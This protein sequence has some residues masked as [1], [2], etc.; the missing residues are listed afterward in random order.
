MEKKSITIQEIAD[1]LDH[2]LLRPDI[3]VQELKEGCALAK[4]YKCISVCVRPSD[5]PIVCEE[6]KGS[7]VLATTVIG[8]PHG[9][10]TTETKVFETQDAV[11]KG[12]VEVDMV[13]NIGRMK[14][15]EYD[16]VQDEIAQVAKAAHEGGALLKVIFEN[17]YLTQ[18]EKIKCCELCKKAGADFIK[19]STGYAGGGATIEDLKLMVAHADGMKVK[20]AGGVKTLDQALAVIATGTVRIG[21][22]SSKEIL[23][24]AVE[25]DKAGALFIEAGAE[26]GGGY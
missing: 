5:L 8:F 14:S 7:D 23:L 3:T 20:A 18:E 9:T 4:E 24:D 1:V 15:G 17:Y 22:R 26:L 6:L 2:S 10:C 11:R 16:Y 13:I 21:T 19:T 12:A 25:R